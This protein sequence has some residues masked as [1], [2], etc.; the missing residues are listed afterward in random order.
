M[1]CS[2]CNNNLEPETEWLFSC[3][4]SCGFSK[5]SMN[6][7]YLTCNTNESLMISLNNKVYLNIF[8]VK[9]RDG[10]PK[11]IISKIQK[12]SN[13]LISEIE[14][15]NIDL[16]FHIGKEALLKK[17]NSYLV[18]AWNVHYARK[19]VS[20]NWI[21]CMSVNPVANITIVNLLEIQ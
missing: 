11:I 10:I 5:S 16:D 12:K 20:T 4:K 3:K 14:I 13:K 19:I 2:I 1:K 21:H 9:S 15:K 6:Y 17:I 7:F 8:S 18:F